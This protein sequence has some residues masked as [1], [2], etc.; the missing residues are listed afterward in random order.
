MKTIITNIKTLLIALVGLIGGAI[1]AYSTNWE[2]EPI[3]LMIISSLEIIAFLILRFLIH[4]DLE[5]GSKYHQSITNNKKIK[6]QIIIQKNKAK[7][8]M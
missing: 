3:I 8:E 4:P 2:M 5:T 1:W 7:I 6:N